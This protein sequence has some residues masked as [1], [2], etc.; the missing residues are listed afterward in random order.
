MIGAWSVKGSQPLN[1]ENI[2]KCAIEFFNAHNESKAC[3]ATTGLFPS[4]P[5]YISE[6]LLTKTNF[7]YITSCE[8]PLDY[9]RGELIRDAAKIMK[10]FENQEMFQ[11]FAKNVINFA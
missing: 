6:T 9:G 2:C 1:L 11:M 5:N 8:G 10:R 4:D 3:K 7:T